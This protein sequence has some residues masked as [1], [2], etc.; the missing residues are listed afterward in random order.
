MPQVS[1]DL[2]IIDEGYDRFGLGFLTGRRLAGKR[3]AESLSWAGIN[4]TY[5][6]ID[7]RRGVAA[8][9]LMQMLP[10]ADAKALAVADAFESG[11]Y[12]L[13]ATRK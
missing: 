9:V 3:S 7:P 6:W 4:N 10:F 11:V 12:E 2:L 5:F 1:N 13:A 8:V